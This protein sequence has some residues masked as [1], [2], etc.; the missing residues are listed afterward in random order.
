MITEVLWFVKFAFVT[1]VGTEL[2][3]CTRW[4]RLRNHSADM[5][6]H[7][8]TEVFI[9]P[10]QCWA[11]LPLFPSMLFT[12]AMMVMLGRLIHTGLRLRFYWDMRW[13]YT[14]TLRLPEV[15]R[16]LT[17]HSWS[18][19]Q[20]RLIEAQRDQVQLSVECRRDLDELDMH[21]VILRRKNYL[22]AMI[23]REVLP[24]KFRLPLSWSDL[25]TWVYLPDGYLFNL[26]VLLFWDPWSPFD[27]EWRLKRSYK[28][29]TCSTDLAASLATKAR[30]LGV[31]NLIFA[32]VILLVQ[33][34]VFVC[35]NAQQIRYQP[36]SI[37]GRRW[38]NYAQLYFRHLNELHHEFVYRI[39]RAYE[40]ACRY[41]NCFTSRGLIPLAETGVFI[42]GSTSLA[43]A[44]MGMFHEQFMHLS[45][46]WGI[47]VVGGV[48]AS[49]CLSIVP[50][51]DHVIDQPQALMVSM[52]KYIHYAPEHW[53]KEGAT[54]A[55]SLEFSQMF[56]YRCVGALEELASAIVTPLLLIFVVPHYTMDIVDFLRNYTAPVSDLGDG[57]SFAMFDIDTYGDP[58]WRQ[59]DEE[60]HSGETDEYH[61]VG[62]TGGDVTATHKQ[63]THH[64]HHHMSRTA[65]GPAAIIPGGRVE[66]SLMHF[67]LTNPSW[68]L[69]N[70][71][72]TYLSSIRKQAVADMRRGPDLGNPMQQQLSQSVLLLRDPESSLIR[73]LHQSDTATTT[74][75]LH[76]N[77]G[78]IKN[79]YH[80]P[81]PV[82]STG[83]TMGVMGAVAESAVSASLYRSDPGLMQSTMTTSSSN[84]FGGS[85]SIL[86]ATRRDTPIAVSPSTAFGRT[87]TDAA[88]SHFATGGATTTVVGSHSQPETSSVYRSPEATVHPMAPAS[89]IYQSSVLRTS[90]ITNMDASGFLGY[91]PYVS[92]I[93]DSFMQAAGNT[94]GGVG[95]TSSTML[96]GSMY[97][98]NRLIDYMATDRSLSILYM[99]DLH[100]RRQQ[101]R[102]D[103]QTRSSIVHHDHHQYNPPS[104][105]GGNQ[106]DGYCD[107]AHLY[108]QHLT[109]SG[110]SNH[111]QHHGGWS[112]TERSSLYNTTAPSF[113]Y[114]A[115]NSS[116]SNI[117]PGIIRTRFQ[118][119]SQ[120]TE[121]TEE[122]D[123]AAATTT[124]VAANLQQ[125]QQQQ[126]PPPLQQ[127]QLGDGVAFPAA[128]QFADARVL[129]PRH[130]SGGSTVSSGVA[131]T[132]HTASRYQS[133]ELDSPPPTAL[134]EDDKPILSDL[135]PTTF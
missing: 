45:G 50:G 86:P 64:H 111:L 85:S 82:T 127:Q 83:S 71:S 9:P 38:S 104:S 123:N 114:G 98:C 31:I 108:Q 29:Y 107:P 46:Y 52:L 99:H 102:R 30:V 61:D 122:E 63:Q 73:S 48:L 14:H 69:P 44:V 20:A 116:I 70:A 77:A 47:V 8:W 88:V 36:A 103:P 11:E 105:N 35:A 25:S 130:P 89:S 60:L 74:T 95:G 18:E 24:V 75:I 80:L 79:A 57:C 91:R 113:N 135:P 62:G 6:V 40:P 87:T 124:S 131:V 94:N 110:A 121:V 43:F 41:L 76:D 100:Q 92:F 93:E 97:R 54:Q 28:D 23:V 134:V 106:R 120:M 16:K 56:Q 39:S 1:F 68:A 72:R 117:G 129:T 67:H 58:S 115:T 34:L 78:V 15:N 126:Q 7:N 2:S 37:V 53:I 13:F 109:A 21:H 4:D 42:F 22:I 101:Q 125:Q 59:F 112:L 81:G 3:F 33:L 32:P 17:D 55:V 5:V 66:L 26:K 133:P 132:R 90:T 65:I 19:V 51:G 128:Y 49:A 118:R 12:V 84:A 27:H 96:G 10:G 119:A